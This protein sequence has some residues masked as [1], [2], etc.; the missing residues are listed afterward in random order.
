MERKLKADFIP[1]GP[2]KRDY[3]TIDVAGDFHWRADAL[4]TEEDYLRDCK[5]WDRNLTAGSKQLRDYVNNGEYLFLAIQ[6][7]VE[8]SLWDKTKDDDRFVAIQTLKCPIAF[9]NLMKDRSC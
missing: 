4:D 2:R 1:I 8:P 3:R 5:I 6:S 9:I 7:Q